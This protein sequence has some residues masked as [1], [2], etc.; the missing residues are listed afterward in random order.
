MERPVT[1]LPQAEIVSVNW[2]VWAGWDATEDERP[3]ES[4]VV[5][6]IYERWSVGTYLRVFDASGAASD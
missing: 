3:P 6:L 2:F 4:T 1:V 5:R